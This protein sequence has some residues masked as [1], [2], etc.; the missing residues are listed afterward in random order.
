MYQFVQCVQ[1]GVHKCTDQ[2]DIYS[3]SI[4]FCIKGGPAYSGSSNDGEDRAS[5]IQS[6]RVAQVVVSWLAA[7]EDQKNL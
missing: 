4:C 2:F 6:A 1:S 7:N 5:F 3:E